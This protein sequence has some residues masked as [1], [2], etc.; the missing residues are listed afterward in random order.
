MISEDKIIT[1]SAVRE[2]I[3]NIDL[4]EIQFTDENRFY[5]HTGGP[6]L[7]IFYGISK[8]HTT[9]LDA[10]VVYQTL[11]NIRDNGISAFRTTLILSPRLN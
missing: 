8:T 1:H 6:K 7:I 3:K 4:T 9:P 10:E 2:I 11:Q 5:M